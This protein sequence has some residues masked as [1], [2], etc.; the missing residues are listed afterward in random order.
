MPGKE[1]KSRP[2]YFSCIRKEDINKGL[3]SFF[4][5]YA[6]PPNGVFRPK[7]EHIFLWLLSLVNQNLS[8]LYISRE[9]WKPPTSLDGLH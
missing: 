8:I 2:H 3:Y 1:K 6:W 4:P 5:P 9:V 7:V